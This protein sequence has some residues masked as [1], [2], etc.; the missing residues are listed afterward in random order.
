LFELY[1]RA[2]PLTVFS[3]HVVELERI[4]P[5]YARLIRSSG[6]LVHGIR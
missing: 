4:E 1:A 5:E 3:L 2:E 6:R